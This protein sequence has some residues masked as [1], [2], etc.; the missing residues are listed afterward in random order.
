MFSK[1]LFRKEISLIT[2]TICLRVKSGNNVASMCTITTTPLPFPHSCS[3]LSAM[4]VMPRR[5]VTSSCYRRT[6]EEEFES[7]A[8]HQRHQECRP[9]RQ[10]RQSPLTEK[11]GY[12]LSLLMSQHWLQACCRANRAVNNLYSKLLL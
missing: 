10:D 8:P 2:R 1:Y 7:A 6:R 4:A 12:C 3:T 9:Q 5:H 11:I